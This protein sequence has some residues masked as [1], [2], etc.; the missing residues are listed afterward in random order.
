MAVEKDVGR[1][2]SANEGLAER[3]APGNSFDHRLL[4][5]FCELHGVAA[6]DGG[7]K[8]DAAHTVG[9]VWGLAKS[10]GTL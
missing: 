5:I 9:Q 4:A 2:D 3:I 10:C 6:Q 1:P 8:F 7:F